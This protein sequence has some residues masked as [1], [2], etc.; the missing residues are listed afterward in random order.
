MLAILLGGGFVIFNVVVVSAI[1]GWIAEVTSAF[2]QLVASVADREIAEQKLK[3]EMLQQMNSIVISFNSAI[4]V[5][6]DKMADRAHSSLQDHVLQQDKDINKVFDEFRMH[7]QWTEE[8]VK[9]CNEKREAT[10]D[11]I[12]DA[13]DKCQADCCP[14][15]GKA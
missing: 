9:D 6:F 1:R 10:W 5:A 13:M 4:S 7:K 3:N 2:K 14:P 11:K 12:Q 8:A 15:R